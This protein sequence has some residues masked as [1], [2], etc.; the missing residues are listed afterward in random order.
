MRAAR[1]FGFLL[2]TALAWLAAVPLAAAPGM[3]V[4]GLDLLTAQRAHDGAP[5]LAGIDLRLA[6]GWKTYWKRPGDSGIPPVFD[7]SASENVASVDL[8]WPVPERFDA[9]GDITYGYE[10]EVV[11]PL[12]VVPE[13]ASRPV[14]LRLSMFYGICSDICVPREANLELTVPSGAETDDG[15]GASRLRAAL[16]RVPVPPADA[17]MLDI[18]WRE[19]SAPALEVSLAGCGK[20]CAPPMLIVDGPKNIWFGTP[21]VKRE[22]DV[23]RYVVEV[24]VLS[25]AMLEGVE[26]GF[27]LSG[28]DTAYVIRKTM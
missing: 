13:D 11:W 7:W 1:R 21:R 20:G 23:V 10:G 17:G 2:V 16:A 26:L 28:P 8:S 4:R 22:G 18:R 19:A 12:R 14:T 15:Q 27:I 9:P 25:P 3:G 24:E 6:E 5:F